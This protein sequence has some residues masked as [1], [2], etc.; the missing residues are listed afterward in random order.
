MAAPGSRSEGLRMRVLPVVNAIGIVHRGII[1]MIAQIVS[2]F[3]AIEQ[4]RIHT[5]GS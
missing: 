2:A 5:R 1:L 4:Q 3:N